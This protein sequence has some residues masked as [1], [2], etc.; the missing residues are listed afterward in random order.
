MKTFRRYPW[1]LTLAVT[2][3]GWVWVAAGERAVTQSQLSHFKRQIGVLEDRGQTTAE[4]LAEIQAA[5][6]QVRTD[7]S[8]IRSELT[9]LRTKWERAEK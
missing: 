6:V 5:V 2:L 8:W 4:R 9:H 7:V 1:L 3:L